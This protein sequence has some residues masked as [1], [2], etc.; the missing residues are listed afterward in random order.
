MSW[1]LA[2]VLCLAIAVPHGLR[3]ES[4]SPVAAATVWL[5]ALLLRAL[6]AVFAALYVIVALP[7]TGLFD[8]VTHWCW[9]T[10][11]PVLAT[12]LGLDGHAFGD[13]ALV[14]PALLLTASVLS[15]A[16]GLWK[17]ARAVARL[18]QRAGVGE[19]PRNS[20]IVG[21][22]DV[23]V[24]AAG[25]R[26][27]RVLVSAGALTSFDDEELDASLE[28]EQ[29]HIARRHRYVLVLGELCR[30]LGRFFPGTRAAARELAFHLERDADHFALR[31]HHAPAALASAIC[32]AAQ[33]PTTA[34]S[35]ALSGGGVTRRIRELLEVDGDAVAGR[36][37]LLRGLAIG[38]ATLVVALGAALPSATVAAVKQAQTTADVRHCAD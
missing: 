10:V 16:F 27:P 37:R 38:M 11:V 35:T 4:S 20:V 26:R 15:V 25:L 9:H 17:A 18:V 6:T 1:A 36:G 21:D 5:S 14:V 3:L 24:A 34:P 8:A 29:G 28:H 30:A 12:H 2:A 32:K 33:R 7:A 13:A 23:L 22:G 19:G 31:R